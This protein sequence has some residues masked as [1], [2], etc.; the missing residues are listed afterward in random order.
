[1]LSKLNDDNL[2]YI[3]FYNKNINT[4]NK[5][6][7]ISKHIYNLIIDDYN[8]LYKKI[9][10]HMPLYKWKLNIKESNM[11]NSIKTKLYNNNIIDFD[12]YNILNC[13]SFQEFINSKILVDIWMIILNNIKIY[14]T[15]NEYNLFQKC[16]SI[17][18]KYELN[19]YIYTP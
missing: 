7:H 13:N 19:I 10:I 8:K 18:L 6:L 15:Y 17:K 16:I 4:L 2:L 11:L 1:M 12:T 9:Y 5:N 3:I 14:I